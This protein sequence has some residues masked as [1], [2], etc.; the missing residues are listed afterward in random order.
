MTFALA[1]LAHPIVQ[2]PAAELVTALAR[3]LDS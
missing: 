1:T 3:E 2:A